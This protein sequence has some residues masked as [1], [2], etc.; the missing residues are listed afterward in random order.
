MEK[1]EKKC[2]CCGQTKLIADFYKHRG[3]RDGH[4]G[5][6]KACCISAEKK[7]RIEKA[8]SIRAYEKSRANL[9]HRIKA[10][11]EYQKTAKGK[12]A[13]SMAATAWIRQHPNRRAASCILNNAIRHGKVKAFP[14]FVCGAKAHA[15]HPDYDRPL[16]VIWLCPKHHKEAHLI[17]CNSNER[18]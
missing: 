16:D 2:F 12:L 10:R 3:M 14:C 1:T 4:Q 5:K 15:H 17:A 7:R 9:P 13:H 18:S 6:C 8:D 11:A